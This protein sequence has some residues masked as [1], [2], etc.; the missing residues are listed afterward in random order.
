VTEDN[1]EGRGQQ[2]KA[3]GP[4]GADPKGTRK[5]AAIL[6]ADVAGYS[7]LMAEDDQA[8]VAALQKA[9]AVFRASIEAHSGRLI[10]T[11][12]D[13]VLAEFRSV[14]EAVQCAV[15]VQEKLK[16][17]NEP[18]SEDRRMVFRIGV[19][20]GDVIEQPD[21]TIY[22]DGVNVAARLEGLAEP[23]TV[24]VSGKVFDEIEDRLDVGF[25]FIGEHEV[26][27]IAKPV[28]A[29]V[30]VPEGSAETISRRSKKRL[31]LSPVHAL[32]GALAVVVV[33]LLGV[34]FWP[35]E[36]DDTGAL[37]VVAE[38]TEREPDDPI[39]AMPSGPSIA[40]LP[41]DNMS[42]DPEQ[43]YFVDGFTEDLITSLS[44]FPDI[45]VI[46]RNS[47]FHFRGQSID[48][49][50]IGRELGADFVMEGSIRRDQENLRVAAQLIDTTDGSHV[51][52]D[53]FDTPL[54]LSNVFASQDTIIEMVAER[55]GGTYG[56]ITQQSFAQGRAFSRPSTLS[57]YECSLRS[58]QYDRMITLEAQ[59]AARTC[60]EEA[61][62]REPNYVTGWA[63][64]AVLYADDY[65]LGWNQVPDALASAKEAAEQAV[66]LGGNSQIARYALAEVHYA[67][68]EERE[69]FLSEA[70]RAI[71]LNPNNAFVIGVLGTHMIWGE[72]RERGF[73]LLKKAHQ[74][75]P[76]YPP[77]QNLGYADYYFWKGDFDTALKYADYGL[78]EDPD[79][80]G[81][82]ICKIALLGHMGR[83]SDAE[84][85]TEHLRQI[86]PDFATIVGAEAIL[87]RHFYEA[88]H[89]AL[90]AEGLQKAG[91][92]EATEPPSR[93]IIAVLP[94]DN[95]SGDP[96]Q[97][98]F[99]DGITEDI[100][101]RLA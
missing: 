90:Y 2:P 60:F 67:V 98:Y 86:F 8:T 31:K 66:K 6:S 33:V 56:A 61:L 20:Q 74:L 12:G 50:E 27:N 42:G 10:D 29:Y 87:A 44:Q 39:L 7:R 38:A 82:L 99:A 9:R 97:E 25:E 83:V 76:F 96:E 28:R 16:A 54:A 63:L 62:N 15:D 34:M 101:T 41:F 79:N 78:A 53:T 88:K 65:S 5:L 73:A 91:M 95:L 68:H 52:S 30:V 93:P 17:V 1:T 85:V 45:R 48:I 37:E 55:V 69:Q 49:R 21:G 57:A 72:A 19:N 84:R 36:T 13:S 58:Y 64:L 59:I 100:I 51:W 75:N 3:E 70:E 22:G 94:F 23:G 77:W 80:P 32:A 46:A 35:H 26:K 4:G 71:S 14:V 81:T 40:V 18:V 43:E 24:N 11:A 92:P 89:V 47:S